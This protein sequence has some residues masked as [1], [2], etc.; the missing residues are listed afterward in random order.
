MGKGIGDVA[1]ATLVPPSTRV[2][3]DLAPMAVRGGGGAD[4]SHE[5]LWELCELL[6]DVGEYVVTGCVVS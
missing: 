5:D 1:L 4:Y 3:T 6:R 2:L